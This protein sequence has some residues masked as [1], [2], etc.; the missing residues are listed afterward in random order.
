MINYWFLMINWTKDV[1]GNEEEDNQ[2]EIE[3]CDDSDSDCDTADDASD[4]PTD[5]ECLDDIDDLIDE[6]FL[7]NEEEKANCGQVGSSLSIPSFD[8]YNQV[9]EDD[10][11]VARKKLSAGIYKCMNQTL[12]LFIEPNDVLKPMSSEEYNEYVLFPNRI[13]DIT[14]PIGCNTVTGETTSYFVLKNAQVYL[15]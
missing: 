8:V 6:N 14:M 11:S 4:I 3:D 10:G 9:V 13:V 1:T 12:S 2:V 7:L 15:M 5:T